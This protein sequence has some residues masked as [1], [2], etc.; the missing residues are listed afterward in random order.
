MD[1][2]NTDSRILALGFA[3]LVDGLANSFLIVVMSPYITSGNIGGESFGLTEAA[4]TGIIL[5]SFGIVNSLIQ[6]FAGKFSDRLGKRKLFIF[7]GLILVGIVNIAYLWVDSYIGMFIIRM[8][9]AGS[10][11]LTV[12][13]SVS[14]V[15]EIS[16]AGNRGKNMGIY[17]SFRLIGFGLG[18]LAAGIVI[19]GGPYMLLG[20]IPLTGFEAT[21]YGAALSA[22]ISAI[23]VWIMVSDP[24]D[25]KP[26]RGKNKVRLLGEEEGQTLDPIFTLGIASMLMAAS[27]SLLSPIETIVNERL[28]QGH[29]MFGIEFTVFIA[30]V[31]LVQPFLGELSDRDGRRKF[32]IWGMVGLVPVTILQ[33]LAFTPGQMIGVRLLQGLSS[34][35]V[36]APALALAGDLAKKGQSGSQLS[37][38]TVSFGLGLSAGQF[39]SGFMV[40]LGYFVPFGVGAGLAA[41]GAYIVYSQVDEDSADKESGSGSNSSTKPIAALD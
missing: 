18:P 33:G 21:F 26:N 2:K 30:V 7:V 20:S 31:V 19:D 11:A 35:L 1:L 10:V 8:F 27:I 23:L 15:S 3:R 22:L 40:Q 13:G 38:L 14:L 24:E 17:N 37:V 16:A 12:V 5:G 32:I 34:A 4:V 28:G 9:Q 41:I 29:L 25:I 39:I 6:P 36:F